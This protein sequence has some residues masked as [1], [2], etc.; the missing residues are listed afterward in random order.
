MGGGTDGG[1][2]SRA[3]CGEAPVVPLSWVDLVPLELV[4]Q[5]SGGDWVKLP[6]GSLAVKQ[7]G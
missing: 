4:N 1:A 2:G 7:A 3:D 6:P 5:A